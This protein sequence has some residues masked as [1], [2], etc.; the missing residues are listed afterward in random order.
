MSKSVNRCA[1][2]GGKFG[3]VSHF[4]FGRRFCRKACR[5]KFVARTAREREHVFKWFNGFGPVASR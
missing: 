2:C 5:E 1:H 4:Y 3:L